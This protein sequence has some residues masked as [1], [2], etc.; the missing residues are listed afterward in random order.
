[1]WKGKPVIGGAV[2]GIPSQIVHGITGFLVHSIEG[3]AFRLHYLLS[4]PRTA[5][6]MG[7]EGREHVRRHFL[8]TRHVRD[9]LLLILLVLQGCPDQP[10]R[11]ERRVHRVAGA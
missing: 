2:G 10:L 6:P 8:I 3:A 7:L 9:Y 4:H 11:L 1:M 5:E